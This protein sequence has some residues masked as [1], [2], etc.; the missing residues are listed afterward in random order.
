MTAQVD[1]ALAGDFRGLTRAE[2]DQLVALGAFDD[3]AVELLD[4]GLYGMS[5]QGWPHQSVTDRLRRHLERA[6]W[7]SQDEHYLVSTH[8]PVIVG[9]RSEPEPDL[10]VY[11]ATADRS[12]RRP[13]FAHLVVEVSE[14]SQSRDLVA[15]PRIYAS[16]GFP[17]CWVLDLPRREVVVHRDPVADLGQYGS[18]QRLPFDTELTVLGVTVRLSDLVD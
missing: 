5:P 6:W 16:A 11:D 10:Y 12:G 17:E 13:D 3:E 15:K 2:Y 14:S 18:V 1:P 4:G 8:S 9:A 7:Q